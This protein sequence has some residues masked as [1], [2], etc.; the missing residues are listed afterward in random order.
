[1]NDDEVKKLF[2]HFFITS[3]H[4]SEDLARSM[5]EECMQETSDEEWPSMFKDEAAKKKFFKE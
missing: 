1:M 3:L 2:D 5:T 4:C